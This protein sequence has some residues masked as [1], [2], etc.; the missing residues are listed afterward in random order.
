MILELFH[1]LI[2]TLLLIIKE[3]GYIGIF[4]GMTVES[5]FF[6]FPSEIVLIPAGALVAKGEMSFF[7]VFLSGLLGSLVGALVNFFLAL[8]LGRKT[9]DL[10]VSKYG[11]FFLINKEKLQKSD[12]YFQKHGEITTFIGR[13]IPVV[14]QLISLPAGF[15]RMN[16]V[17]FCFYTCL[18]AGIWT[19]ILIYVGYLFGGSTEWIDGNKNILILLLLL[20]S[21]III[22][23]YLLLKKRKN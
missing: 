17:K 4:I 3:A 20:L 8:Y 13:L 5:S 15:S 7:L 11:K 1:Q 19:V 6:P 22:I 12:K 18:G 23:I 9:V 21:L 2:S 14:R 16:F 10:L